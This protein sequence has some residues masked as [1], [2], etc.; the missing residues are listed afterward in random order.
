MKQYQLI[1][2]ALQLLGFEKRDET[3]YD[4]NEINKEE[5]P[6][7]L[8]IRTRKSE[9]WALYGKEDGIPY[10]IGPKGVKQIRILQL[11]SD[12][13]VIVYKTIKIT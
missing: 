8:H 2:D 1:E 6:C 12:W 11:P 13:E 7:I 5:N 10:L 9:E 4:V 3:P